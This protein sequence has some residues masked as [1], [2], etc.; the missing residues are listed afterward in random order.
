MLKANINFIKCD[1]EE[2]DN[3]SHWL[4]NYGTKLHTQAK[5]RLTIKIQVPWS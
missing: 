4:M 5:I 2:S 3:S 1:M